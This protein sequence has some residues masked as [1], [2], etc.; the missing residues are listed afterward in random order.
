MSRSSAESRRSSGSSSTGLE[1]PAGDGPI[2]RFER[3]IAP[4]AQR[5]AEA[6]ATQALRVTL[7][8]AFGVVVLY[9]AGLLI[10][11]PFRGWAHVA[12]LIRQFMPDAFALASVVTPV[13]EST[14]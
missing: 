6:P 4:Y 12:E 7:P 8:L 3:A 9:L 10:H 13:L 1:P 5:F 14:Q 2:A 11:E